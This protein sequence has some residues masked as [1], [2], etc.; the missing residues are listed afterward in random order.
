MIN[1]LDP[2][3]SRPDVIIMKINEIIEVV[4]KISFIPDSDSIYEAQGE[5]ALKQIAQLEKKFD[6]HVHY[7]RE[8][9]MPTG[10]PDEPDVN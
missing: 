6:E 3:D 1:Q 5:E 10:V 7:A 8:L 4:N 9:Q 2:N